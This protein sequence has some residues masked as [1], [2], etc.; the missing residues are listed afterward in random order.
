MEPPQVL[1]LHPAARQ[2]RLARGTR[3]WPRSSALAPTQEAQPRPLFAGPA[4]WTPWPHVPGQS[5]A[6]S[7]KTRSAASSVPRCSGSSA[8]TLKNFRATW[9]T[10]PGRS[11]QVQLSVLLPLFE[12]AATGL[13]LSS[14]RAPPWTALPA[15]VGSVVVST[16]SHVVPEQVKPPAHPGRIDVLCQ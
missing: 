3:T 5:L 1:P 8:R 10:H 7:P 9:L 13:G 6:D 16:R 12:S 2:E 14:L 15:S 4:R 11:P